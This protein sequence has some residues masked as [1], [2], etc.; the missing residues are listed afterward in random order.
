MEP[1]K[2]KRLL[3]AF[4]GLVAFVIGCVLFFS[5]DSEPTYNGRSLSQSLE[6]INQLGWDSSAEAKDAV[7]AIGT[8]AFPVCLYWLSY[9]RSPLR[10]KLMALAA[11]VSPRLSARLYS[12]HE[13][14]AT[15]APWV[16]NLLRSEAGPTLPQ[17]IQLAQTAV[18][19]SRSRRCIAALANMGPEAIPSLLSLATNSPTA[20]RLQAIAMLEVF[21][22]NSAAAIP[23]L[24]PMLNDP[25]PD[26]RS[27]VNRV[28][29]NIAP[30]VLTNAPPR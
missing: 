3:L 21:G 12:E 19:P 2:R 6:Q 22:T 11:R 7:R 8:N 26:I 9:E 16:F 15:L 14:R 18:D 30:K 1:R 29:V 27:S 20:V 17:L 4:A 13:L 25:H 10:D 5:G 28:L 23:V 24:N